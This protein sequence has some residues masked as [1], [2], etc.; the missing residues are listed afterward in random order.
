MPL[1][2]DLMRTCGICLDRTRK[3]TEH[4]TAP[5]FVEMRAQYID[6][7]SPV[8]VNYIKAAEYRAVQIN[9]RKLVKAIKRQGKRLVNMPY[10]NKCA[11]LMFMW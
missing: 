9:F 10:K 6:K 2:I 8:E 4:R 5:S 7:D 3:A 11:A 1:L